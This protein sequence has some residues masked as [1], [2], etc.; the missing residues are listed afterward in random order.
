MLPI[1][2]FYDTPLPPLLFAFRF[3]IRFSSNRF[4]YRARARFVACRFH[5]HDSH[6]PERRS[7]AEQCAPQQTD[8]I[9]RPPKSRETAAINSLMNNRVEGKKRREMRSKFM[10]S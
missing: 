10:I 6:D 1:N 3:F 2:A 4:T 5:F 8:R 9:T 7:A